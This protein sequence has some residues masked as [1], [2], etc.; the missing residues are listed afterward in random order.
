MPRFFYSLLFYLA[1]PFILLR[2][3]WR[4]RKQPGYRQ[5]WRERFAFYS[6]PSLRPSQ[7]PII[8]LHAV[9]VGETRAAKPL[10]D[11]LLEHYPDYRL[12]ITSTTPTG[13]ATALELY[14]H[15]PR[16]LQTWLP[17]DLP[18]ATRRFFRRFQPA[19]GIVMETEIW[20]N[21]LFDAARRKLPIALV[22]ARLSSRSAR[23]YARITPLIR[24]ALASLAAVA[25]QSEADANRLA[26]LGAPRISICG[27]LK[28]DMLPDPALLKLGQDWKKELNRPVWLA[29]STREG[30]EALLLDLQRKFPEPRPLLVLVPRHPQRFDTVAQLIGQHGLLFSRRSQGLPDRDAEVWLG[31]SMGEMP[32]YYR[33]ADI[34]FIGGSLLPLGG[35]NLIEAAAAACPVLIGPHTFNFAQAT[36]DAIAAGAARRVQNVSELGEEIA[37]LLVNPTK[38][39]AMRESALAFAGKNRGATELTLCLLEK[40]LSRC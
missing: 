2:L 26:I 38:L 36:L 18:G 20:P 4:G 6:S 40:L 35:Q 27:N 37:K 30:E 16:I 22:N 15:E 1:T 39:Q 11:A 24:P 10:I 8:W 9:S 17:Y 5:K 21:L 32:A 33:L 12:L 34:A 23:A 28:F 14:R 3:F 13:Y 19:L 25:A 31:D 29:A 7:M